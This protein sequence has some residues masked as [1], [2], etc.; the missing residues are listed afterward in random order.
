MAVFW[1]IMALESVQ[2]VDTN[3]SI[4]G[5]NNRN[6]L[7]AAF[8]AFILIV[9]VGVIILPVRPMATVVAV[10]V[11]V[12]CAVVPCNLALWSRFGLLLYW[13]YLLRSITLLWLPSL[14]AVFIAVLVFI[15]IA[16]TLVQT[17][18]AILA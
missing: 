5:K 8:I 1:S 13:C 3:I 18:E 17:G 16:V 9:T 6:K 7:R 4:A 2:P 12:V 14:V 10:P 11:G 15:L